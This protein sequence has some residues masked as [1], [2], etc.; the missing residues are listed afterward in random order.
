MPTLRTLIR[1]EIV[2]LHFD[3]NDSFVCLDQ[4][5]LMAETNKPEESPWAKGEAAFT[6]YVLSYPDPACSLL[7]NFQLLLLDECLVD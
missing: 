5:Y 1:P 3:F 7:P 6:G 4:A 2:A